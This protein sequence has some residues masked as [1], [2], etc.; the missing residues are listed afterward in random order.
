MLG[1]VMGGSIFGMGRVGW[2]RVV[3]DGFFTGYDLWKTLELRLGSHGMGFMFMRQPPHGCCDDTNTQCLGK[4][5]C[6]CDDQC[7]R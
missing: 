1:G 3:P 5:V 7:L 2:G 6:R 4:E